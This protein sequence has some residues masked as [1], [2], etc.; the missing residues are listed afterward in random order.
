MVTKD[1]ITGAI[2]II[3]SKKLLSDFRSY[4]LD[5]RW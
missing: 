3:K 5:F 4:V 1:S 2:E